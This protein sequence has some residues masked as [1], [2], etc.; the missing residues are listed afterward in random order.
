MCPQSPKIHQ[1]PHAPPHS[2]I[3]SMHVSMNQVFIRGFSSKKVPK[4]MAYMQ[5]NESI[6][7]MD[8]FIRSNKEEEYEKFRETSQSSLK[9]NW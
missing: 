1:A 5:T 8:I 6:I 9:Y 2:H 7:Y 3:S 4:Q